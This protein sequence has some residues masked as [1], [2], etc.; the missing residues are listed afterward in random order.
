MRLCPNPFN[1]QVGVM[2]GGHEHASELVRARLKIFYQR[3]QDEPVNL[4]DTPDLQLP[5]VH[6]GGLVWRIHMTDHERVAVFQQLD[7]LGPLGGI[8][9]LGTSIPHLEK[10]DLADLGIPGMMLLPW[11]LW[12]RRRSG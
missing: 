12:S 7:D 6:V 4:F 9:G 8:I 2:I 11:P 3:G 1:Q 10:F 5:V